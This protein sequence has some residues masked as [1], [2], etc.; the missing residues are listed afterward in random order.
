MSNTT[1]DLTGQRFGRLTAIEK[2]SQNKYKAWYWKCMC[3][4]GNE[5]VVL[6]AQLTRSHTT[7]CGCF[8]KELL[9]THGL[10]GTRIYRI[11]RLMLERCRNPKS[12]GYKFY[13]ARGVMVCDEWSTFDKFFIDM[14]EGYNDTLSIERTDPNGDYCKENCKW[15]PLKDQ[16]YSKTRFKNNKSGVMGVF[17]NK[18]SKCWVAGWNEFLTG[19]FKI[20]EFSLYK[21]GNDVAFDL[22]CKYR[23]QMIDEQILLGAP[24]SI[25]HG[26]EK[27]DRS[28]LTK[29]KSNV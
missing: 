28:L 5:C 16:S 18:R 24:Y 19:D 26:T 8:K 13:G 15:I 14:G 10:S 22:A 21:Y 11:Y 29:E 20:K 17:F 3:D 23:K 6:G 7:S 27:E 9:T 25:F 4:C 1:K 12:P 2:V